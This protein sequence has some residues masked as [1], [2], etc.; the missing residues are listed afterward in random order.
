MSVDFAVRSQRSVYKAAD[1]VKYGKRNNKKGPAKMASPDE[2][3]DEGLK[4]NYSLI[5]TANNTFVPAM[6]K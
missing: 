4:S 1:E 6:G 3:S 2:F 5:S